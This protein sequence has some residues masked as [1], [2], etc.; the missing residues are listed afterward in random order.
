MKT[1]TDK[2]L[3]VGRKLTNRNLE[4]DL[5]DDDDTNPPLLASDFSSHDLIRNNIAAP[6]TFDE[7]VVQPE[8][9]DEIVIVSHENVVPTTQ[10]DNLR[11]RWSYSFNPFS[12]LQRTESQPQN[13]DQPGNSTPLSISQRKQSAISDGPPSEPRCT[14]TPVE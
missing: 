6:Q 2:L 5:T 3:A 10:I 14:S 1:S 9:E 11:S 12:Y 8:N 7:P 13:T 4:D